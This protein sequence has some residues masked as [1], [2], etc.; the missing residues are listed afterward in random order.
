MNDVVGKSWDILAWIAEARVGK[1]IAKSA[2]NARR[3]A[4]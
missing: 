4:L 3:N 1:N 2:R